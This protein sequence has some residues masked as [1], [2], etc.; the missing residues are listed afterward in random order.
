MRYAFFVNNETT[1]RFGQFLIK[2]LTHRPLSLEFLEDHEK[3]IVITCM[4]KLGKMSKA[5]AFEICA[6]FFLQLYTQ[7]RLRQSK[8]KEL[9]S[10]RKGLFS[11]Q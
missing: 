11:Q 5:Y 9:L 10:L 7:T 2:Y 8:A 6:V 1:G 3:E 4:L